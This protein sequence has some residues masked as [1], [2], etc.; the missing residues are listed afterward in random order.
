MNPTPDSHHPAIR[1]DLPAK[2]GPIRHHAP[3]LFEEIATPIGSLYLVA[4]R[5]SKGHLRDV[6]WEIRAFTCS[7]SEA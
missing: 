1:G 5:V 6:A 2:N 3:S 7:I 4:D